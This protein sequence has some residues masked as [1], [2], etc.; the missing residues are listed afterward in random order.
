MGLLWGIAGCGSIML[1][2]VVTILLN[3]YD[4]EGSV[5]LFSGFSANAIMCS[6]LLQPVEWHT[7]Y[8]EEVKISNPV[9]K[10]SNLLFRMNFH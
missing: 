1:P 6:L 2:H 8:R 10:Y 3:V 9:F 5:L 7:K 4:M